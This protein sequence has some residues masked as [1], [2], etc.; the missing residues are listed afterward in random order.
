MTALTALQNHGFS[1]L[2]IHT[3]R[4]GACTCSNPNCPSPGK[5]PRTRNGVKDASNDPEVVEHV[6]HMAFGTLLRVYCDKLADSR[7]HP[8]TV[9]R[10]MWK[11]DY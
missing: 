6:E 9:R 2:P 4:N 11:M 5:H 10:Y 3:I 1:V 7:G 8:L